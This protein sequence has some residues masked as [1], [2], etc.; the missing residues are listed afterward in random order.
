M[1]SNISPIRRVAF[2]RRAVSPWQ[3]V[4][5]AAFSFLGLS[6]GVLLILCDWSSD[7]IGRSIVG[8][9]AAISLLLAPAVCIGAFIELLRHGWD[10]RLLMGGLLAASG[11]AIFVG[12]IHFRLREFGL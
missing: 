10:W 8:L 6:C 4:T 11:I 5:L 1:I 2:L 7:S 9:T 12:A 3:F